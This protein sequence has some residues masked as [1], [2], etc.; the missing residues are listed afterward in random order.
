MSRTETDEQIT[1]K[2]TKQHL[3]TAIRSLIGES[4][5]PLTITA[6]SE[7][8]SSDGKETFWVE[9]STSSEPKNFFQPYSDGGMGLLD[10]VKVRFNDREQRYKLPTSEFIDLVD[11]LISEQTLDASLVPNIVGNSPHDKIVEAVNYEKIFLKWESEQS[12]FT[13]QKEEKADAYAGASAPLLPNIEVKVEYLPIPTSPAETKQSTP[14]HIQV[15]TTIK[16]LNPKSNTDKDS[17][18]SARLNA[19]SHLKHKIEEL[20]TNSQ[21][22]ADDKFR[23]LAQLSALVVQRHSTYDFL[24]IR[25]GGTRFLSATGDT[26]GYQTIIVCIQD[27]ILTLLPQLTCVRE[28]DLFKA[29][30]LFQAAKPSGFFGRSQTRTFWDTITTNSSAN[31]QA[32][33]TTCCQKHRQLTSLDDD[34]L[35]PGYRNIYGSFSDQTTYLL[36]DLSSNN[37]FEL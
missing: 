28:R 13:E 37:K 20:M 9:I 30:V 31:L 26:K 21:L 23:A 18:R 1:Y 6:H 22:S 34:E 17:V 14:W 7:Q 29:H 12:G 33:R 25:T 10:G 32:C 24:L 19:L 2:L 11:V 16:Q 4:D 5:F 36:N 27:N 8:G 15:L 35:N 3:A